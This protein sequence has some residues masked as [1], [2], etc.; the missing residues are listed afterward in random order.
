MNMQSFMHPQMGTSPAF[1][2]AGVPVQPYPTQFIPDQQ[3]LLVPQMSPNG[4]LLNMMAGMAP[5]A[6]HSGASQS[7]LP[8][9]SAPDKEA[10]DANTPLDMSISNKQR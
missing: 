4:P 6:M 1:N 5:S 8:V 7:G 3:H 10:N 2:P 9:N